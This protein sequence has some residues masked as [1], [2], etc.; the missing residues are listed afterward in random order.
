VSEP[1]PVR[2][3]ADLDRYYDGGE[4]GRRGFVRDIF[5]RTADDYDRVE[6]MMAFGTGSWYRRRALARSGLSAG[7]RVLDVAIGTGLVAR[8]AVRLVGSPALVTGLDPSTG[9]VVRAWRLLA[10]PLVL[11][12]GESLP[13]ADASFDFLSL[14]YALRHLADLRAA[15]G[16]FHRVLRPGGTVCLL[17]ITPPRSGPGRGLLRL[18]VRGVIPLLTRLTTHHR[19]TALL[20]QYFWDTMEGCVPPARVVETLAA[21]GFGEVG[22][23]LELGMFSEY[24]GRRPAR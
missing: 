2:P 4:R 22:R 19:E 1:A 13:F 9:M 15:F 7:A 6:R 24:T 18:Y 12:T 8:E 10:T 17:E 11:G 3:H 16:E 20:W 5:D 21:A 14:G 23:F